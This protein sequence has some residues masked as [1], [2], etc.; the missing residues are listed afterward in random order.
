MAMAIPYVRLHFPHLKE[1]HQIKINGVPTGDP[2]FGSNLVF[3]AGVESFNPALIPSIKQAITEAWVKKWPDPTKRPPLETLRQPLVWGPTEWP[4]D[5][6]VAGC[7]VLIAAAREKDPPACVTADG[8]QIQD[9][10]DPAW[11]AFYPGAEVHAN[12]GFFGYDTSKTS[13]GISCGLNGVRLTGRQLPRFDSRPNVAQMFQDIP[14]SAPPP[15][16]EGYEETAA[17]VQGEYIPAGSDY[18]PFG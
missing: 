1:P 17:P 9:A 7:W 14:A 2:R 10:G 8:R 5:K 18:N 3:P 11:A 13:R 12:L 16:V 4:D 15:P 6:T